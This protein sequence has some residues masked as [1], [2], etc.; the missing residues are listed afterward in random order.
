MASIGHKI[1][2]LAIYTCWTSAA[3]HAGTVPEIVGRGPLLDP[4]DVPF[5][6]PAP[7]QATGSVGLVPSFL[8][9]VVVD[10]T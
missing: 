7:G 8:V 2:H 6:S 10:V 1:G 4:P 9:M 3:P 5:L